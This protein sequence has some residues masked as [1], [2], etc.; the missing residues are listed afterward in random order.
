M[1]KIELIPATHEIVRDFYGHEP[2]VT[3]RAVAAVQDGVTLGV[4]GIFQAGLAWML[5]SDMKPELTKDKRAMVKVCRSIRKLI[6]NTRLPVYALADKNIE[7]SET[8]INHIGGVEL[9]PG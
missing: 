7:G 6:E 2:L 9:W 4:G 3:M 1:T 5:F 8:L